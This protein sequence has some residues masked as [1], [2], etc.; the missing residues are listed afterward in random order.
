MT[1]HLNL[2]GDPQGALEHAFPRW[3][4]WQAD[5][6]R[7]WASVRTNLT[8]REEGRGCEPFREAATPGE[9]AVLLEDDDA[10]TFIDRTRVQL[11]VWGMNAD[12]LGAAYDDLAW[13]PNRPA[14]RVGVDGCASSTGL[15]C[16]VE[17]DDPAVIASCA[18]DGWAYAVYRSDHTDG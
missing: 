10:L 2:A 6:G 7:W 4:V 3:R 11:R 13:L 18:G 17:V 15:P 14:W 5:S 1:E 8:R 9:L 16:T 12:R